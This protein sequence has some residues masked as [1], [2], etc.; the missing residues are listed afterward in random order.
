MTI[1]RQLQTN[2]L[3]KKKL[4]FNFKRR[5]NAAKNISILRLVLNLFLKILIF[6]VKEFIKIS[7]INAQYYYSLYNNGIY[8]ISQY[9][10]TPIRH[11]M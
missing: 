8:G 1:F 7:F 10:N 4:N 3:Y 5:G 2:A 9:H 6:L 11:S